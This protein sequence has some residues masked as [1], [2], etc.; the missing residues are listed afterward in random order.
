MKNK[1]R[2]FPSLNEQMDEIRRGTAEI[3]PEADLEKKI[4][5]S[6][7]TGDPMVIKF[8]ADP[9]APD[10][11]IGHAVVINK[12]RTFQQLGHQ[13]VF[14]IGD[15]TGMVGDP[16]GKSKTRNALTREQ[17]NA[18]AETYKSQIFKLL[19]PKATQIRFNSEWFEKIS[20]YDFLA[21][22][23]RYTVARLLER[24]D[25][26]KRYAGGVPIAVV[27]FLYPLIQGYDSVALKSDVELGGTDQTFNLLV[28]RTL[29]EHYG[30]EAQV[31]LTM[32]ILEG[33][34]GVQKMS[35]SLNNYIGVTD[36]PRDMFGRTMSIPDSMI[37]RWYELATG[38]PASD[39]E[40]IRAQLEAGENPVLLKRRLGREIVSLYHDEQ[41]AQA[42]EQEFD[43]MF[44][45]GGLPEDMP[46]FQLTVSIPLL[47]LLASQELSKSKGDARKLVRQGAVSL[48]G[49][50]LRDESFEFEP[51]SEDRVLKVGKR[52]FLKLLKRNKI[53]G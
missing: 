28:G 17:V 20:I 23:S 12:L 7:K 14:L 52:R 38:L 34:D 2:L 53:S 50:K 27:E 21:L 19:D 46:E 33:T 22:T 48:D 13:V 16:S 49:E 40:T 43:Q 24:D 18:N 30:Q 10:L 32:P 44:Q 8:G 47:D 45:K 1:Q 41:A 15:F 51:S 6:I 39:V 4:A 35:K 11:H 25:F 5:R 9:S 31:I 36:S 3:L 29:Q 42:A 37:L 26:Q